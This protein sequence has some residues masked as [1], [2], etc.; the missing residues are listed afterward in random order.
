MNVTMKMIPIQYLITVTKKAFDG[1][2]LISIYRLFQIENCMNLFY[3]VM[4][5]I[6][7]ESE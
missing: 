6:E 2:H 4:S 5:F 1:T 7:K 3:F